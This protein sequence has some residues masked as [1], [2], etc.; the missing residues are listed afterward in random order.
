MAL[1]RSCSAR[2]ASREALAGCVSRD[3]RAPGVDARRV[4][5][6]VRT[7]SLPRDIFIER[8][9]FLRSGRHRDQAVEI[10][11]V[12]GAYVI[13]L[14]VELKVSPGRLNVLHA[15]AGN[16]TPVEEIGGS[17][18]ETRIRRFD[19]GA[20]RGGS[21]RKRIGEHFHRLLVP[22]EMNERFGPVSGP[23]AVARV[24]LEVL[25]CAGQRRGPLALRVDVAPPG[26][27]PNVGVDA[28]IVLAD[29][30][31]D[32]AEI[33]IPLQR[34]RRE[35][36]VRGPDAVEMRIAV[37]IDRELR[38]HGRETLLLEVVVDFVP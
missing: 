34:A 15:D 28:T 13:E 5:E 23:A 12:D 2:L 10:M 22:P 29:A 11:L 16:A 35:I 8:P 4:V 1:R 19:R 36:R 30:R 6:I 27:R 38:G 3:P 14:V 21:R 31:F 33:Q 26:Q 20:A 37:P 17:G 18:R 32:F 25:F 9:V 7:H 24:K